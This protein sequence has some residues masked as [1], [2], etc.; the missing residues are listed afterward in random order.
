MRQEWTV[1][2]NST[3]VAMN[4]GLGYTL[5]QLGRISQKIH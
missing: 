4:D 1:N 2:V 5:S 3:C